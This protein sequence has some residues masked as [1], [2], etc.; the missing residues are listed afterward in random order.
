MAK[1]VTFYSTK[2]MIAALREAEIAYLKSDTALGREA[3]CA[4]YIFEKQGAE[5]RTRKP[6]DPWSV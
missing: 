5:I 6:A 3:F 1:T 2:D 4:N